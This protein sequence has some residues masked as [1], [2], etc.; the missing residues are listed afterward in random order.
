MAP[1]IAVSDA[2]GARYQCE[3]ACSN[4]RLLL[5]L[6]TGVASMV[7]ARGDGRS[8]FAIRFQFCCVG[9]DAVLPF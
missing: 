3:R 4:V 5:I 6:H 8:D 9:I 1:D 2:G 7:E